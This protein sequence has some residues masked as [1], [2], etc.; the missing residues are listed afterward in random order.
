MGKLTASERIDLLL[1]KGSFQEVDMMVKH[2]ARG[3]GIEDTTPAGDAVV[4]GFGMIDGRQVFLFAEDFTVFGGSLGVAVARPE[5]PPAPELSRTLPVLG[6]STR[7]A[8]R[9]PSHPPVPSQR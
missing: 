8:R 6:G 3:F 2:Q 7:P 5:A 9:G 1:D 4:A